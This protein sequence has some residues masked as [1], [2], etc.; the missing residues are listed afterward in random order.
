MRHSSPAWPLWGVV[1]SS[2]VG[3]VTAS[4]RFFDRLYVGGLLRPTLRGVAYAASAALVVT[5]APISQAEPTITPAAAAE[6]PA[7]KV[8]SRPDA[9]SA[10]VSARAQG[11]RVEVEDLRT[12]TSSTW[13]NPDGML[14][15]QQHQGAIRFKDPKAKD[16]KSAAW[17]NVN[18]GFES[19]TDGTAGPVGHP[20]GLSL[21]G[22]VAGAGKGV[23]A[24]GGTDAV[25]VDEKPGRT[26][27]L[28][29]PGACRSRCSRTRRRRTRRCCLGWTLWCIRAGR[30]SS[31]MS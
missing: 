21:A 25:S 8:A 24:A 12:E 19:K 11:S 9:V 14:T 7:A 13:V 22:K 27:S 20:G 30:V 26:V 2:E 3:A 31:L 6:V 29:W 23:K 1:S 28:G 10:R 5:I 17:V 15:T 18:L 4:S 16:V